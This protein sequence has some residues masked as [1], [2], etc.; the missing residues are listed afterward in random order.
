MEEEDRRQLP[1]RRYHPPTRYHPQAGCTDQPVRFG[2]WYNHKHVIS[3]ASPTTRTRVSHLYTIRRTLSWPKG[4]L[5]IVGGAQ[6]C[7]CTY[8]WRKYIVLFA[9]IEQ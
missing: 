8:L 6:L 5:A 4:E 3:I 1:S 9:E 7:A 2:L